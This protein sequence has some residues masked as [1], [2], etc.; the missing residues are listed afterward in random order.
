ML[1][2][3]IVCLLGF[4]L[5]FPPPSQA[6]AQSPTEEF[7]TSY[8]VTYE[9]APDGVTTVTQKIGL[10]N[11]TSQYFASKYSLTIGSTT[12]TDITATDSQGALPVKTNVVGTK[13][14]LEIGFNQ[15]VA[16]VG[17]TLNFTLK[18][19]SKDFAQKLGK[20]W[21]VDLPKIPN[22]KS[23][24]TYNLT[25]SVPASFGDPTSIYP[26]PRSQ[27]TRVDR[28]LLT[29]SKDQLQQSG[30]SANFG[31]DQVFD[32]SLTY[33]LTNSSLFPVLTS[34]ALPSNTP[35]Q[36]VVINRI[37]P[38]PQNVTIDED[39]NYLAWYNLSRNTEREV[40]VAGSGK[41]YIS[42]QP[43]VKNTLSASEQERLLQ[44]QQYWEKDNPIIKAKLGDIF[45][46]GI[47]TTNREKAK[48]IYRF[49]AENLTYDTSRLNNTIERLGAITALNNPASAV[50]MEFTDTFVTLARAAGVPARALEGYALTQ[51]PT[52]RPLSLGNDL[53]AWPEYYDE[54]KGWVMV[55]P[56]W[57][58]TSGG[59]DY[60]NK[61]DLNHFTLVTKGVSSTTPYTAD[62]VKVTVSDVDFTGKPQLEINL[63]MANS[64]WAGFPYQGLIKVTNVGNLAS[65]PMTMSIKTDKLQI[66]GPGMVQLPAIP[67]YGST[68][69]TFNIRTASLSESFED[70]VEVSLDGNKITKQVRVSPFFFFQS[71]PLMIFSLVGLFA[72]FYFVIFGYHYY[73][74]RHARKK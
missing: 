62:E 7:K 17:K 69:Y 38:Q 19:K 26:N 54:T 10:K 66:F 23:I 8:D 13:T 65:L 33:K 5:L 68:S 28:L 12:L 21:E 44:S 64:L 29:Y 41:V 71:Y 22:N 45:Q 57:E 52:L 35:Y 31:R 43:G 6:I 32:F 47:P 56:T 51:N 48:L 34:I 46:D 9:V 50:C 61:F 59:I 73:W 67:P 42:P 39:G 3:L 18:F 15:Q 4:L 63:E 11:L 72:S 36:D 20:T 58:N 16:G 49:V 25:L 70:M 40:R 74:K 24:E 53:H 1:K 14:Q 30:V 27:S 2:K 55:D 60:F 37:D